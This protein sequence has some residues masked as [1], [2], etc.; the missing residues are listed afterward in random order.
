MLLITG[1]TCLAITNRSF[2]IDECVTAG[3]A[4]EGTVAQCW[5]AM[6]RQGF[7]EVQLPLYML[8]AWGYIKLFGSGEWVLRA[9]GIPW[10]VF[11][12]SV[13]VTYVGRAI[14]SRLVPL[15]VIGSS[16][17]VWYYLNEARV[18]S[19][20]LGMALTTVGAAVEV[21][22]SFEIKKPNGSAWRFFLFGLL[23]LCGT[24][25]LGA[26]WGF[27][28]VCALMTFIPRYGWMKIWKLAPR[29][30]A[31]CAVGLALLACY[32]VWTIT[33]HAKATL[34]GTTTP[35]T[36]AFVFYELLGAAGLG[37]GR[38]DL[39]AA[40]AIALKP[41]LVPVILYALLLLAI[42]WRGFL[43]IRPQPNY[44]RLIRAL[45]VACV[46]ILLIITIG[47]ATH[48]RVLGRHLTPLL[49]LFFLA[50]VFGIAGMFETE[51]FVQRALV[52]GFFVFA[53]WSSLSIRFAGRHEKDD[54]RGAAALAKSFS[55]REA[56]VWWNAD[57][58][59]ASYYNVVESHG[60]TRVFENPSAET[61]RSSPLPDVIIV[62]KP[63][64][65]DA[66]GTM[67][68]YIHDHDFKAIATR[69]AFV[70]WARAK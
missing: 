36:I 18:Y 59:S 31:V 14:R 1:A 32:Y 53:L 28:F 45:S 54:S 41:F 23:G 43:V 5:A 55:D 19:M 49:P 4:K 61:L 64:A 67:A 9:A 40:G 22:R 70:V 13:F 57:R 21:A 26:V 48:F 62:S 16:A 58:F 37:P 15:A 33:L 6:I 56:I 12:A 42:F 17:F 34:V 44:P 65:F 24:S 50:M 11:G 69:R 20:Q 68:S 51:G 30:G 25:L 46:P 7:P 63:E 66:G 29:S 47:I 2:W 38:S 10:F 3:F 8:Y 39:R 60:T 27:F 35:S 52:I